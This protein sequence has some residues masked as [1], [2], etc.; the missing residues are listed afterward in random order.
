MVA[1]VAP[2]TATAAGCVLSALIGQI[3][4]LSIEFTV[5]LCAREGE[6]VN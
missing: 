5:N 6:E 1:R 4:A 3:V 2:R